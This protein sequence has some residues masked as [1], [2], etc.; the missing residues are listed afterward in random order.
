M[1][2]PPRPGTFHYRQRVEQARIAEAADR[3]RVLE[4]AAKARSDRLA[5]SKPIPKRKEP[6]VGSPDY[7]L[8]GH[9]IPSELVLEEGHQWPTS[10]P[11]V[12]QFVGA[13]RLQS[14]DL[15]FIYLNSVDIFPMHDPYDAWTVVTEAELH[16]EHL[17]VSL[18]GVAHIKPGE[19]TV[20]TP[21]ESWAAERDLFHKTRKI[22]FFRNFIA[23][24]ALRGWVKQKRHEKFI[25]AL[26]TIT[27]TV[28]VIIWDRL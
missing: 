17:V 10:M 3:H 27:A 4:A 18:T 16:P 6:I 25:R 9:P 23:R 22:P 5:A 21:I 1:P 11:E 13:R 24:K 19:P 8:Q 26:K 15:D 12:L 20:F 7:P 14:S 2:K 28:A